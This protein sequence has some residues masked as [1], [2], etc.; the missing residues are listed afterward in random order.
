MAN[1]QPLVVPPSNDFSPGLLDLR[2]LLTEVREANGDRQRVVAW[3][4]RVLYERSKK[5]YASES[6]KFAAQHTRAVQAFSALQNYLLVD[7][8]T[9]GLTAVG[10]GILDQQDDTAFWETFA[11]HIL[12][13]LNGSKVIEAV[14]SL[15]ARRERVLKATVARELNSMGF[16]SQK[17]RPVSE[18]STDHLHMLDWLER[19]GVLAGEDRQINEPTFLR[20]ARLPVRSLQ[21][22]TSLTN[23]Q[24]AFL[25]T[26][27]KLSESNGTLPVPTQTVKELCIQEFGRIF[28][29]ANMKEQVV[30]PLARH[31]WLT[32]T[33]GAASSGTVAATQQLIDLDPTHLE[34]DRGVIPSGVREKLNTPLDTLYAELLN[35]STDDRGLAL[36]AFA[37]RLAFD[38]CLTPVRLRLHNQKTFQGEVDVVAEGLHLHFSR[39][40][41]QCKNTPNSRVG[42]SDFAK[43][44]G[45]AVLLKAHVI[46]MVTT[47]AFRSTVT[48]AARSLA[49]TTPLQALLL[50]GNALTGY[51]DHGVGFLVEY[52]RRSAAKVL[53]WKRPQVE[54]GED[55]VE[56]A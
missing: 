35:E 1:E 40:L 19:A 48:D 56:S 39:W 46:V 45:M 43:E 4:Q 49:E 6:E 29:Q 27:K 42:L 51:K 32:H 15:H 5:K 20:L 26:L 24:R 31:G 34:L 10:E 8:D 53:E 18:T 14:R 3:L 37:A 38:L 21:S 41:F 2:A 11:T 30:V 7:R 44:I 12:T 55:G 52:I 33:G 13:K 50:D 25:R 16:Q 22:I 36:E 23:P 28:Q 54:E 17:G 9:H 47:G